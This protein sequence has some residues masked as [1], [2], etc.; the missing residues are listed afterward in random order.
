MV[1]QYL[2]WNSVKKLASQLSTPTCILI[3]LLVYLKIKYFAKPCVFLNSLLFSRVK[4]VYRLEEM[5]KIFVRWVTLRGRV[6]GSS[7]VFS[8]WCRFD[9]PQIGD[10]GDK[11]LGWNAT[12]VL[13]GPRRSPLPAQRPLHHQNGQR[14]ETHACCMSALGV[15]VL[16]YVW[17]FF[18]NVLISDPWTM[19]FSKSSKMK[20]FYNKQTKQSTYIMDP[21]AIAPF[22]YVPKTCTT[23]HFSNT[24]FWSH[25]FAL[26]S[27]VRCSW[28]SVLTNALHMRNW[29]QYG[30]YLFF[31][32][33]SEN[34][35]WPLLQKIRQYGLDSELS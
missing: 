24:I 34:L 19:G 6:L 2:I 27:A 22:Q 29:M 1:L 33:S 8:T 30:F 9:V 10:E 32:Q 26:N 14:W 12:A 20:F 16:V 35:V 31:N 7:V 17:T 5:D 13:H 3:L 23:M 21:S 18:F 25:I 15:R 28:G 4:E 11:E